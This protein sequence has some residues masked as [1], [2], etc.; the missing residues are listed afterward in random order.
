MLIFHIIDSFNRINN[1]KYLLRSS[2][3]ILKLNN[4]KILLVGMVDS[5]HF[6]KWVST[7]QEEFPNKSVLVFPSD[8]P[9]MTVIKKPRSKHKKQNVPR[10][11]K[12]L[13]NLK[14]NFAV[15]YLL[16]LAFGIK[17]RAYF[18]AR[19][20]IKHKPS[21]IHF[22]EMQHGAY[23]YNL[24]STYKKIPTNTRKIISTWGSDLTLYSWVDHHQSQLRACFTWVKTLTAERTSELL[25][26]KRLGFEGEYISPLYITLGQNLSEVSKLTIPSTRKVILVKGHQSDT[27]RAL[28]A[29]WAISTLSS[30]LA[31][32]EIIVYSA[33]VSVQIQ[34]DIL[35]NKN[36][37]NIR[38][39]ARVESSE[40]IELFKQAR[41][42]VSL[43]VSDGLPGVLVEAMSTGAFPIQ[44]ENSTAQEFLV[45][46]ENGLLVEPWDL[47]SIK[48]SI[49]KAITD[50]RL[51]DQAAVLNRKVLQEKYSLKEGR[52]KLR[53]LYL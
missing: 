3:K 31:N 36:K 5:P 34:V 37:I 52:L 42:S 38:T 11:F 45:N 30:H 2:N 43:A 26:A 24:I 13:I 7:V 22:H 29:L 15:F 17:W 49:L 32:F 21:I 41:I 10:V 50:D 53:Q 12:L 39:L 33:P 8:R 20:I 19:L 27:G 25:D 6:K 40:M 16:D 44:S 48:E 14:L 23:I 1:G 9:R 28:N 35:R 46:S 4:N 51:V 18:L 47:I